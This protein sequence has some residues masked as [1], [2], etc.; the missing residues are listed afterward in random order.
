MS[1][2]RIPVEQ[3]GREYEDYCYQC[4]LW[5]RSPYRRWLY[6]ALSRAATE[7]ELRIVLDWLEAI[8]PVPPGRKGG[9]V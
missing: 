3:W 4:W 2:E 1:A 6:A 5:L 7:A 8:T 9:V